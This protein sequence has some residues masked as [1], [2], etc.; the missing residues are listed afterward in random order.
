MMSV[1]RG[2]PVRAAISQWKLLSSAKNRALSPY[3]SARRWLSRCLRRRCRSC[4]DCF[5][6]ASCATIP[7]SRVRLSQNNSRTSC[8]RIRRTRLPRIPAGSSNPSRSRFWSASRTGVRDTPNFAAR[9]ASVSTS[10][11]STPPL[12][13]ACL[14]ARETVSFT[15]PG[16]SRVLR[17]LLNLIGRPRS[18]LRR[19]TSRGE[20]SGGRPR[21]LPAVADENG[22]VTGSDALVQFA[23]QVGENPVHYRSTGSRRGSPRQVREGQTLAHF[24]LSREALAYLQ[25]NFRQHINDVM[26]GVVDQLATGFPVINADQDQGGIQGNRRKGIDR[27]T[28]HRLACFKG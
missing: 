13:M 26:L 9:T 24:P 10:L 8:A 1:T 27:D 20:R 5:E 16:R 14:S 17:E 4:G 2:N 12:K 28:S 11:G 7:P 23:I 19:C 15:V 3:L 22:V 25:L 6:L 18:W 21:R